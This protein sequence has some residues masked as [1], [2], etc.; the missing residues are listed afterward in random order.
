M[1][2]RNGPAASAVREMKGADLPDD[3]EPAE[4]EAAIPDEAIRMTEDRHR[5]NPDEMI[6]PDAATVRIRSTGNPGGMSRSRG[7]GIRTRGARARM[8]ELC[9]RM[10][11]LHI[12]ANGPRIRA[13]ETA[14]AGGD[15]P[16]EHPEMPGT[17]IRNVSSKSSI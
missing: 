4:R 5:E 11:G 16:E 7:T 14:A 3:P 13:N 8:S 17:A 15:V 9:T 2:E 6:D 12:R 10:N 1:T